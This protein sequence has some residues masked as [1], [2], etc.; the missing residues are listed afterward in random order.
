MYFMV[1]LGFNLLLFQFHLE[2][3]RHFVVGRL[4]LGDRTSVVLLQ[5]QGITAS[6]SRLAAV[7]L[8][9]TMTPRT[10]ASCHD[11][12]WLKSMHCVNNRTTIRIATTKSEY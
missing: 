11:D 12:T 8:T 9:P 4:G 6:T 7:S 2:Q 3:E 1:C 10:R 5:R